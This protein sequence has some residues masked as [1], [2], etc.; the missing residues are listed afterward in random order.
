MG[1]RKLVGLSGFFYMTNSLVNHDGLPVTEK[2]YAGKYM[3][4]Y[5]GYTFCPDIC[6]EGFLSIYNRT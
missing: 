5:F 1:N 3:L 2:T 6:P 4:I